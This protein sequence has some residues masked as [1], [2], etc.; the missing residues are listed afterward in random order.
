[1][2]NRDR[3]L[4]DGHVRQKLDIVVMSKTVCSGS[5]TINA[6][7]SRFPAFCGKHTHPVV[8]RKSSGLTQQDD[9]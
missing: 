3:A 7:H 4:V 9:F 8:K 5:S 1:M 2:L 6:Y